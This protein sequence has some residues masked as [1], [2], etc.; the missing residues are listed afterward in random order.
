MSGYIAFCIANR[1]EVK[2]ANPSAEFG[3]MG[4]LLRTRWNGLSESEKAMYDKPRVTIQMDLTHEPTQD[5]EPN[6]VL[7]RSSRLRNKRLG[8]NF[9]GIK[10]KK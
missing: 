7:R 2:A 9:W 3:D 1:E 4:R 8:V 6:Q 5:N 10:E